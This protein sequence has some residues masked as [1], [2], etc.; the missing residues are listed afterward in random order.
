[1]PTIR[2]WWQ[3]PC[4]RDTERLSCSIACGW[5]GSHGQSR[6]HGWSDSHQHSHSR[7]CARSCRRHPL[8]NQQEQ[9]TSAVG[10]TGE[11]AK[12]WTP[13]PS[14]VRSRR[15]VTF[16]EHST[17]KSA[18]TWTETSDR[19]KLAGGDLGLSP[20]LDLDPEYFLGRW[21]PQQGAD[22]G[23]DP[24]LGLW[25]KTPLDNHC[26]WIEWYS[27]CVDILALWN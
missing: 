13:S 15:Q 12:R 2:C 5:S 17:G 26:K 6:S 16:E 8:V 25:P 27:Q 23:R 14:P 22:E 1:M 18:L 7:R 24:Q 3:P 20:S 11:P 19:S 10:H 21:L 9:V 4:L